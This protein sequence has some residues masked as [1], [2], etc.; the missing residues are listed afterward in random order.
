MLHGNTEFSRYP[1]GVPSLPPA[2]GALKSVGAALQT[3]FRGDDDRFGPGQASAGLH[4]EAITTADCPS[5][6]G[7]FVHCA[8][9]RHR[10][11]MMGSDESL[12]SVPLQSDDFRA[13]GIHLD[14]AP[15]GVVAQIL[16]AMERLEL[17]TR[18]P[19]Y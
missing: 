5:E 17:M 13:Q 6:S 19:A 2:P 9:R 16:L 4:H 15:N 14:R 8:P 7:T 12:R 3:A 1:W 18:Q 10:Q 11:L